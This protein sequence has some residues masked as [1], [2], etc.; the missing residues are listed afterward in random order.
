MLI[1]S[2]YESTI[3]TKRGFHQ[4]TPLV[5][6]GDSD[7]LSRWRKLKLRPNVFQCSQYSRIPRLTGRFLLSELPVSKSTS[8]SLHMFKKQLSRPTASRDTASIKHRVLLSPDD[9]MEK[10]K[11]R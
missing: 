4:E 6:D 8:V 1:D 11:Y 10:Q 5:R 3:D 7:H 9:M 2:D